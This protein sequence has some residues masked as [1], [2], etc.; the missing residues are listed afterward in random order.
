MRVSETRR[1]ETICRGTFDVQ[2]KP[3]TKCCEN[4]AT[5]LKLTLQQSCLCQITKKNNIQT[6]TKRVYY[7]ETYKVELEKC[8]NTKHIQMDDVVRDRHYITAKREYNLLRMKT[9]TQTKN[10]AVPTSDPDTNG[11]PPP[12]TRIIVDK[13]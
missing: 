11:P 13:S 7:P 8:A 9:S 10:V 6:W 4:V 3:V 12:L 5:I 1:P 2:L